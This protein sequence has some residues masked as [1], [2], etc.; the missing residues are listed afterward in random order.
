MYG[1]I[2]H[3]QIKP[4]ME[5]KLRELEQE[6]TTAP[7]PGHVFTY[8]YRMDAGPN[9]YYMAIGFTSKEAYQANAGSPEQD[10]RYR[11]LRELLAADPEWHDGEIVS[12][13]QLEGN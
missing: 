11:K 13:S 5:A 9:Q 3:L 12:M 6:Y 7:V 8:V 1:T 10:A 4:G 2:A